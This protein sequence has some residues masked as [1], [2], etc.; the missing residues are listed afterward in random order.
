MDWS[1][2]YLDGLD[3]GFFENLLGLGALAAARE[4]AERNATYDVARMLSHVFQDGSGNQKHGYGVFAGDAWG[5]L[6][7]SGLVG[8]ITAWDPSQPFGAGGKQAYFGDGLW[9]AASIAPIAR[10]N[11]SLAHSIG[12]F[13]V[14]VCSAS[15]LFFPDALPAD[16]QTDFGDKRNVGNSF[17]YEALRACDYVRELQSCVNASVAPF[18]TGDYGCEFPTGS[19]KC[20]DPAPPCTNLAGYSGA[21][22]GVLASLCAP[23]DVQAVLQADLLAT[24]RFH[25]PAFPAFLVY[26]PH[27][28]S[29]SAKLAV[30]GCALV[31]FAAAA[32]PAVGLCAV[33]DRAT[34]RVLARGIAPGAAVSIDVPPDTALVIELV[35]ETP[36]PRSG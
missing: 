34:G 32:V 21:S 9:L 16:H 36:V 6:D 15:R 17:P 22:V 33:A 35:P 26:N 3:S 20:A 14:N 28:E 10:Y 29:V 5:G 2:A 12:R 8:F 18:Q 30:P 1:L 23:T 7:V 24:D 13:L 25:A 11:T 27:A 19:P 4:N 31:H